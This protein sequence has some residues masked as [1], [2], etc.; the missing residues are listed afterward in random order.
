ALVHEDLPQLVRRPRLVVE[1][2]SRSSRPPCACRAST[3]D[4]TLSVSANLRRCHV[5]ADADRDGRNRRRGR[6]PAPWSQGG[7]RPALRSTRRRRRHVPMGAR[8]APFPLDAAPWTR[9]ASSPMGGDMRGFRVAVLVRLL[10]CGIGPAHAAARFVSPAGSDAA[11]DCLT[12]ASPCRTVGYA[13]TQAAS[14]DTVKVAGGSYLENLTVNT[15][16]TLSLSGG[17]NGAFTSRD[18]LRD[19]TVLVGQHNSLLLAHAATG[20]VI[21]V[22]L[23]GLVLRGR[24]EFGGTLEAFA[25]GGSVRLGLVGCTLPGAAARRGHENSGIAVQ[26]YAGLA[27]LEVSNSTIKRQNN[28]ILPWVFGSASVNVDLVGSTFLQNGFAVLARSYQTGTLTLT[29]SDCTLRRNLSAFD[30]E[31]T[32]DSSLEFSLDDSTVSKN[33]FFG[34]VGSGGLDIM[35]LDSSSLSARIDRCV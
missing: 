21:D 9:G 20:E 18:N 28:G 26:A 12:S 31:A 11:N 13:L 32:D 27:V 14:G 22:T 16:T 17:W 8:P 4:A 3:A 35:A 23:D 25:L 2:T 29:A 6:A 15:A 10:A 1:G 19:V 30:V 5:R 33:G 34:R 7:S 24:P